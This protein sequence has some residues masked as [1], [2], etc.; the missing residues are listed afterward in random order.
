MM[1]HF[2]PLKNYGIL[3][4]PKCLKTLF[5]KYNLGTREALGFFWYIQLLQAS[6]SGN[7]KNKRIFK[8]LY[9]ALKPTANKKD[10]S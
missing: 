6:T 8:R 4:I 5:Q 10:F 2:F 3:D 9:A 1:I 7:N